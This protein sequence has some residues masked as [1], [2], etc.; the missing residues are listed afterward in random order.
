MHSCYYHLY[1]YYFVCIIMHGKGVPLPTCARAISCRT[2]PLS[3]MELG[4]FGPGIGVRL[5]LVVIKQ[6]LGLEA[7]QA[8]LFV[9][10][11][12]GKIIEQG[13]H[14]GLLASDGRYAHLWNRQ[15]EEDPVA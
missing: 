4:G 14:D 2:A 10:L 3:L 9:V 15:V 1:V 12:D 5:F 11:E 8:A 7:G 6:S 13:T